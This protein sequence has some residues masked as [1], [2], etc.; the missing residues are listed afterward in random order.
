MLF[1]TLLNYFSLARAR[2]AWKMDKVTVRV[3]RNLAPK[4]KWPSRPTMYIPR[5][6]LPWMTLPR[7]WRKWHSLMSKRKRTEMLWRRLAS[8]R[9]KEPKWSNEWLSKLLQYNRTLP[10]RTERTTISNYI[11]VVR[12]RLNTRTP[13]LPPRPLSLMSSPTRLKSKLRSKAQLLWL[14]TLRSCWTWSTRSC[15]TRTYSANSTTRE[16]REERNNLR[17]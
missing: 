17:M 2:K 11:V 9:K 14:P 5:L 1:L 13:W 7:S 3:R 16:R 6:L 10:L 4:N 8:S 12:K 15:V